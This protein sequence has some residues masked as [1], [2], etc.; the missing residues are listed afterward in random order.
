VVAKRPVLLDPAAELTRR[1][2][3]RR[4]I[5]LRTCVLRWWS[6]QGLGEH[7]AVVGKRIALALLEQPHADAKLAGIVVLHELLADDLSASDLAAF[8]ALFASGAL[9][10][11]TVVDAFAIKVLGA[12]LH[13]VRGRAEVAGAV[14]SWRAA[15]TTWQRRAACVAFT[16]LA[17]QGDAALPGLVQLVLLL[18]STVV[19]SPEHVEQ[20]AVG[21][22]L[23]E[24]SRAEPARVEAFFRRHARFMSR[25]C[26]RQAVEKLPAARQR[27]L[28]AHWKRATSLAP[29]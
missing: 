25:E 9:C 4:R 18:C 21:W 1:L 3:A 14:A 16:A 22:L 13:H 5:A 29:R 27:E 19:W 24:L 26:A 2:A 8:E 28:L 15:G 11:G 6:E 23:R 10:D 7:P 17:A 12:M 20:T